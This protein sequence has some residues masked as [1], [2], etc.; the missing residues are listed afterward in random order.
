MHELMKQ[1]M[2]GIEEKENTKKRMQEK[3]LA[4]ASKN[5]GKAVYINKDSQ[6]KVR[7]ENKNID[8]KEMYEVLEKRLKEVNSKLKAVQEELKQEKEKNIKLKNKNF[9]YVRELKLIRED[10]DNLKKEIK[11]INNKNENLEKEL[12]NKTSEL[13]EVEDFKTSFKKLIASNSQLRLKNESYKQELKAVKVKLQNYD[14]LDSTRLDTVKSLNNSLKNVTA[15][16]QAH[17]DKYIKL[18]DKFYEFNVSKS[19][20][21]L[22]KHLSL[23]TVTEYG[24]LK[25]LFDR[26]MHLLNKYNNTV[27]LKDKNN[28]IENKEE[29][30]INKIRYGFLVGSED[31]LLFNSIEGKVYPVVSSY[32]RI[33]LDCPAKALVDNEE[34][35]ILNI[36]SIEEEKEEHKSSKKRK[37]SKAQEKIPE[38][39]KDNTIIFPKDC[40]KDLKVLIVGS[41]NKEI[42]RDE[43]KNYGAEVLWFDP[44][45]ESAEVL[46]NAYEQAD[47]V[48]LCTAHIK[49]YVEWIVDMNNP[50]VTSIYRDNKNSMLIRVRYMAIT[51]GIIKAG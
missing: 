35:I 2:R 15:E 39:L 37:K 21:M 3:F 22:L 14:L 30:I 40:F 25:G 47:I 44:F 48:V 24:S 10:N 18:K 36:Y 41:R 12:N 32:K 4:Q 1:H 29:S 16:L 34:A 28:D 7:V 27:V 49:H 38:E 13:R 8:Y 51:L 26:Y 43:L 6:D 17:K 33:M 46:R 42:Y 50:K 5:N 20:N 23:D 9:I 31:N 19:I 45:D 11:H